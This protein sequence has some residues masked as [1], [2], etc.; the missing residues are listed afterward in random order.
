MA[1]KFLGNEYVTD[2]NG[3][4]HR[5]ELLHGNTYFIY[6]TETLPGFNLDTTIYEFTVDE[7]GLIDGKDHFTIKIANT[8]NH[9]EF[10]KK[11]I[12]GDVLSVT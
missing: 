3:H 8:P 11:D 7:N 4:I 2:E 9:V 10:S 5:E 12:T 6:E 1:P